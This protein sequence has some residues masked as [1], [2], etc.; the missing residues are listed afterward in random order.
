WHCGER[1]ADRAGR[2]LR[3][4]GE[5]AEHR[6]RERCDVD[7]DEREVER[8]LALVLPALPAAPRRKGTDQGNGD[9][10][11]KR[12]AERPLRRAD[13]PKLRPLGEQDARECDPARWLELR[14]ARRC[15][16]HATT[17]SVCGPNSTSSRVRS[18]NASSSDA[19]CGVSSWSA[20][21][22]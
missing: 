2:I 10:Q 14:D 21:P 1:R 19:C 18:M 12:D 17:S 16:A 6:D 7:A 15:S 4:D 11:E 20:M 3:R 9:R 13:A 5:N 22:A 8:I